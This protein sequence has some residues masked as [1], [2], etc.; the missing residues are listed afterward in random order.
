MV[1]KLAA[2]NPALASFRVWRNT[3][4]LC[5]FLRQRDQYVQGLL[6]APFPHRA[7]GAGSAR[8]PRHPLRAATRLPEKPHREVPARSGEKP[9]DPSPAASSAHPGVQTSTQG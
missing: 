1:A 2:V 5:G 8:M 9:E 6:K 7:S 4:E 3:T